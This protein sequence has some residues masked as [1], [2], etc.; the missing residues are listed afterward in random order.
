MYIRNYL[1]AFLFTIIL[2]DF[3]T[4]FVAYSKV[5]T[6]IEKISEY[7]EQQ[8]AY[9]RLF[10]DAYMASNLPTKIKFTRFWRIMEYEPKITDCI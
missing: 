3:I 7:V 9:V 5:D 4:C 10:G 1:S 8:S 6:V 2:C